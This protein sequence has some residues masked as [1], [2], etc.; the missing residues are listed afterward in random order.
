MALRCAGHTMSETTRTLYTAG[1]AQDVRGGCGHAHRTV[2]AAGDCLDRDVAACR[3]LGGGAYS[4]RRC[5]YGSDGSVWVQ[6]YDD[7]DECDLW[8]RES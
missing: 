5:V 6:E 4:D 3:S 2:D 1:S 8:A 7:A